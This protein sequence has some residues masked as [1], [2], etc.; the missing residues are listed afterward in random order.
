M[1]SS[2]DLHLYIHIPFCPSK[3]PFCAFKTGVHRSSTI[4][5]YVKKICEEM[6]ERLNP[7]SESI[8]KTI[9]IG[10]GT[11]NLLS[12][13]QL[14]KIM[15]T[16]VK[17]QS[18][19]TNA[20]VTTELHPMLIQREYIQEMLKLGFNRFSV[21]VQSFQD[22]ELAFLK[23][24]YSS[25]EVC[26]KITILKDCDI[27]N[28]NLDFIIAL[29]SQKEIQITSNIETALKFSP[30]HLSHYLL[31]YDEGS[32]WTQEKNKGRFTKTEEEQSGFLYDHT[33]N[34]LEKTSFLHYEIS[35]WTRPGFECIHHTAFWSAKPYLG[36]GLS[37]TSFDQGVH[38]R[39]NSRLEDYFKNPFLKEET[40]P[41]STPEEGAIT[42]IILQSRTKE[43]LQR[44]LFTEEKLMPLSEAGLLTLREGQITLT[45]KGWILNDYVVEQLVNALE[46]HE[47]KHQI[48]NPNHSITN[49]VLE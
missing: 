2:E 43:G 6:T 25:K 49:R 14:A 37:A 18:L 24:G 47:S 16:L 21:G 41:C 9:Y 46:D 29:P 1:P 40:L 7:F 45:R 32:F 31:S 12:I 4:E 15:E 48:P 17:S 44:N 13:P 26:G 5:L 19:D 11:T 22:Q 27:K 34:L 33:C 30:Q 28:L 20:E 42:K 39:N 10:G 3:C 36:F 35:N 38:S 23:R 8:I